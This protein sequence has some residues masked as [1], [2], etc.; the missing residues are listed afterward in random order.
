MDQRELYEALDFTSVKTE[1]VWI[2]FILQNCSWT[3]YLGFVQ[4]ISIDQAFFARER[5]R[6][7]GEK[8]SRYCQEE[9]GWTFAKQ[10]S[11]NS[12]KAI[13]CL[14]FQ[15]KDYNCCF[16]QYVRF[17]ESVETISLTNQIFFSKYRIKAFLSYLVSFGK[18]PNTIGNKA[19]M[20]CEVN[21]L[22]AQFYSC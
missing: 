20:F 2:L 12:G 17:V 21:C 9:K 18:K 13:F 5:T 6:E 8:R 3:F 22:L 4:E 1:Y 7:A 14:F 16:G 15:M 10:R 19:K 11:E